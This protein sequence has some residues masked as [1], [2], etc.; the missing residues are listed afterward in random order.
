M[1]Q[2]FYMKSPESFNQNPESE[3]ELPPSELDE[4]P[5][6][7]ALKDRLEEIID[8]A[9]TLEETPEFNESRIDRERLRSAIEMALEEKIFR[10]ALGED[11]PSEEV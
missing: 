1:L 7:P 11:R 2:F 6:P 9:E 4:E 5:L 3:P 8:A 10:P